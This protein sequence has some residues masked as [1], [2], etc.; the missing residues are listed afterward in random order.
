MATKTT[1][2]AIRYSKTTSDRPAGT[3]ARR[4]MRPEVL[5]TLNRALDAFDAIEDVHVVG[6]D[7]GS[8]LYLDGVEG[9]LND[10]L[11][12]EDATIKSVAS[13]GGRADVEVR[14]RHGMGFPA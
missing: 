4:D 9:A 5:R 12:P 7:F 13:S 6:G 11:L 10:A 2:P 1:R 14:V 3:D 8:N